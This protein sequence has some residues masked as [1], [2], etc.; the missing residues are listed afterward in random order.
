ML[1]QTYK[2]LETKSLILN[3]LRYTGVFW[4]TRKKYTH[5]VRILTYH[6]FGERYIPSI[7]FEKQIQWFLDYPLYNLFGK[8]FDRLV[9]PMYDGCV[10][11][12]ELYPVDQGVGTEIPDVCNCLFAKPGNNRYYA[13]AN[14]YSIDH[15]FLF[16]RSLAAS[17][18]IEA[19]IVEWI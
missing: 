2:P 12:Y 7:Q 17:P 19:I 14:A 6:R 16:V 3:I 4:C 15:L 11:E 8:L 9:H 13:I 1:S 10:P 5:Q 18:I